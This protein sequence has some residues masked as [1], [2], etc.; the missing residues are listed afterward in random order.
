MILDPASPNEE[1]HTKEEIIQ[2]WASLEEILNHPKTKDKTILNTYLVQYL[3]EVTDSYKVFINTDEDLFRM[4]LLLAESF[5]FEDIE[6]K[7]FCISKFL[8]LLNIDL[9][10]INMKFVITYILLFEAKRNINSLETMLQFQ[11]FT[12]FYN[13]LYTEFAYL[14]KYGDNEDQ[15]SNDNKPLTDLDYAIVDEMKQICTVLLDIL[16]QMFKYCKCTISNVQLV[17]DFFVHF[18]I[19]SIRSDTFTDLYNNSQFKV[20][21]ALNEQ[22]MMFGKEYNIPN[23]VLKFLVTTNISKGFMELLLLKFNRLED[24]SLQIMMCKILYLILTTTAHNIAKDFFY[25][26]DLYVFV[27]VLIRELQNISENQ[28]ALRNTYLRVLIPLL[29][30]TELSTTHYRKNELCKV[31]EYL[32]NLD[33]I[34][35]SDKILSEHK[36]T[37]RLASKCLS[38][39]SWLQHPATNDSGSN[40]SNGSSDNLSR[41]STISANAMAISEGS[42]KV[43]NE[44]DISTESL[45]KRKTKPPPPPPSRKL[46]APRGLSLSSTLA[47]VHSRN[48][49]DN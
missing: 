44:Y 27:D 37:V 11:G 1:S 2:F 46:S 3:K 18:L 14:N 40:S 7:N 12:V 39:V 42:T 34:C 6:N 49:N 26:N 38:S 32:C 36:T 33:N 23:K 16:Y 22:Y 30:N 20:I 19:R 29:Q 45:E 41:V 15:N 4:A 5:L 17:D 9:L 43:F 25:L 10:E 24:C 35:D 47:G 8:S 48:F 31:L 21:L 28:E 13:T